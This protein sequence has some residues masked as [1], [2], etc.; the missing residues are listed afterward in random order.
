MKIT[1]FYLQM[2]SHPCA[3]VP[4]PVEGLRVIHARRPTVTYYRFLYDAV[5]RDWMWLSRKRLSDAE[6]AKII[7]DPRVEIHVL[8]VDGVPAG[9]VE[10]DRRI[11]GE[12]E[13]KQFGLMPEFIGRGLGKWI[14]QWA[15]DQAWSSSSSMNR[16][17]L[18]TCTC[19]HPA[20]IPNYLKAGFVVYDEET[21]EVA[22]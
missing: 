18:H 8:H 20:A 3:V 10:F 16:L 15:I 12:T 22:I 1:T 19:D 5:G 2:L 11:D 9:F 17:W 7:Q 13:I 21:E 14:L 4:A 6:L